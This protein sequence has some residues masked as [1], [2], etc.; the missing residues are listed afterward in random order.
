MSPRTVDTVVAA[1]TTNLVAATGTAGL[2]G[3]KNTSARTTPLATAFTTAH[4]CPCPRR[5]GR[6]RHSA[7]TF[8]LSLYS[9]A[10]LGI[11]WKQAYRR[12]LDSG[13]NINQGLRMPSVSIV[14]MQAGPER[15]VKQSSSARAL[16]FF[17][18]QA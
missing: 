2:T 8:H 4:A 1:R 12:G 9:L 6:R 13:N 7:T 11:L 14:F 18:N 5:P 3:P 17:W 16:L 10:A 15:S